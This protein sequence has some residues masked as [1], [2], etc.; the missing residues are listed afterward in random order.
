MKSILIFQQRLGFSDADFAE[1]VIWRVPVP[2]PGSRHFFKYRLAYVDE[3][4]C[5]I[6]FDN[7][8]GKGDHKHWGD[9]E[10]PYEFTSIQQLKVDFLA[11]VKKWRDLK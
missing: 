9:L 5:M 4:G 11:D 8:R 3:E 1:M 6:R 7:E 10:F 2:V